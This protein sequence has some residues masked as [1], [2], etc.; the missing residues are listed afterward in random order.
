MSR[1]SEYW[2]KRF[3]QVTKSELSKSDKYQAALEREYNKASAQLQKDIEAWYTKFARDNKVTYAEAKRLLNSRELEE[4]RWTVEDY[5]KYGETNNLDG[6]WLKQLKNASAKAHISRLEALQIQMQQHAEVVFGNQLDS[7]DSV[8]R[9]IYESGYYHS[10][11]EIQKGV[12]IGSS[13]AKLDTNRVNKVLANPWSDDGVEFSSRVWSNRTKLVNTLRTGF[14]QSL[15]RGEPPDKLATKLVNQFNV[16]KSRAVALVQTEA[17][18]IA[19]AAQQD[20]F[21]ELGVKRLEIIGTLD[22]RTCDICGAMDGEE[23][24]S[25]DA[26]PGITTP[27]YH[28]RCRCCT[29]PVINDVIGDR[30]ARDSDG[31]TYQVPTDMTYKDWYASHVAATQ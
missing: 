12:G 15:I 25:S 13:F 26:K 9:D 8:M 27:P 18:Q 30:A 2:R 21:A 14:A 20:C 23:I 4:L 7:L 19:N 5:I 6:K 10:I 1:N 22:S 17:A 31:K 11:F 16:S 29:A 28:T 3:E 24:D